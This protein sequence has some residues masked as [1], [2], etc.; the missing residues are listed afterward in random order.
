[1]PNLTSSFCCAKAVQ[2][3][4]R[5]GCGILSQRNIERRASALA[6]IPALPGT[7]GTGVKD[8]AL[9]HGKYAPRMMREGYIYTLIE[10]EGKKEWDG[11]MVVEDAFL[12]K[13]DVKTPPTA[14]VDFSCDRST[15]GIDASCIAIDKVDKVTKAWL[16]FTP[17]PMTE[18]KLKEYKDNADSYAGKGKMQ[19]FDPKAWA[20]AGSKG[21]EH[22]L[23]PELIGQHVPEWVLYKQCKEASSSPLGKA[24]A[25]QLFPASTSAYA[26]VPP[27]AP[28]KPA[29]G[30]LGIL[31][32]KLK[33]K[34]GVAFVLHDH[35]GITQELND[36]RNSKLE[37]IENYLAATDQYGASNQ[38]RLQVYEA[39]HEVKDGM[40]A[41][42]VQSSQKFLDNHRTQSD[43]IWER[44]LQEARDLRAAGKEADAIKKEQ[45]VQKSIAIRDENYRRYLEADKAGAAQRWKDK[46]E[47]RLDISEMERFYN[48]LKA[49]TKSAYEAVD[50]RSQQHL[51][52]F[53]A[54]RT[55][56]AFDVYDPK[57]VKSGH[58]FALHAALCTYGIAG[59]KVAEDKLDAWIKSPSVERKNLYMRGLYYNQTELIDAAKKANENIAAAVGPVEYASAI[60]AAHM[61]KATKGLVDGFKKVDSAFD[62]WARNQGQGY[63]KKWSKSLEIILYHKAS[64]ITRTV[65]RAGMGGTFDKV[66]TARLSGWLYARLGAV[67]QSIAFDELML[68]IS[69]EKIA[70]HQRERVARR[71]QERTA[72]K[73][74]VQV[75]K[76]VNSQVEGSLEI[77]IA[78][79]QTKAQSKVKLTLTQMQSTPKADLPTNNYH[80]TRIGV[81]L[82]CIEMIAL[83]E[84]LTHFEANTKGMLEVGG[85]VMAVGSIVLDTYYSAAKSIREIKPYSAMNAI[86][87]GADIVRGGF[88]LGAGVLGFGAGL[89]GAYLDWLKFKD[90]KN[91]NLKSIYVLR[92]ATGFV[93]SG[94]TITAAFSYAGPMLKHVAKGYAAHSLRYRALTSLAGAAARIAARVR[95]LVWVARFNLAGLALTVVEIGYL[96]FKDD[97]L[98]NWCEKSVFRKTK[99]YN[100]WLG[101]QVTA[102]S[103]TDAVKELE[104]LEKASQVVGAT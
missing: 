101:R 66:I 87:K 34:E 97:D 27:P 104:E 15:C 31:L 81:I 72:T 64:D 88:K 54:D 22:S 86:D 41:G 12:Y 35:I 24:M 4:L 90:E 42:V 83:G 20:K 69:P 39:I 67:G 21:Q 8:L 23:K 7:L 26:G 30:R 51:L 70:A 68:K 102:E 92:A 47:S 53:E 60:G 78:D 56:N 49:H 6:D 82:G 40:H 16:L 65:F 25:Q 94:F 17:S 48:K 33:E 71:A 91:G 1:M 43:A 62:E 46:Y 100:N 32:H 55:V 99:T 80:Q 10:R 98:Q 44:Q 76:L 61:I 36:Y 79:A 95:L 63:S 14:Q 19:V 75:G 84:K 38:Q 96:F 3:R 85:S 11:Y 89:C 52:W 29:P 77:L 45:E 57:D 103:Y 37:G 50:V 28:D 59:C 9:T 58:S 5:R 18:A 73:V 93:G 13:F 74:N 2:M